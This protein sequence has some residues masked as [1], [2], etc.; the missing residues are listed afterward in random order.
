MK[1]VKIGNNFEKQPA[2][3]VRLGVPLV[4]LPIIIT[5][6]FVILGVIVVRAHLKYVGATNIKSYWDFVPS[7]ISHRY[8]YKNQI[9]Y[10]TDTNWTHIRS[11]KFYWIFNCNLYCPMSVALFKYM[12]YLVSIVENWWCPFDHDKKAEYK[13]SSVDKSYWHL[14]QTERNKLHPNDRDNPVWNEEAENKN[15]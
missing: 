1:R 6:P 14:Y 2:W 3:K 10:E 4:Y 9:V 5:I 7:W 12:T 15:G 13:D 11:Y 8:H